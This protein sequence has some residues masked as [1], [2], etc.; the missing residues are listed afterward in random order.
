MSKSIETFISNVLS[1]IN[2]A[3]FYYSQNRE[4]EFATDCSDL[5]LRSLKAAGFDI[6]G[7]TYTGNMK[8]LLGASCD[9]DVLPFNMAN[10]KR[11]D[12]FLKHLSGSN[13]HTVLYL[14]GMRIAEASGKKYGLREAQYHPNG[15]QW[16][17]RPRENGESKCN[18]KTIKQGSKCIEV[19]L[20]QLFLNKYEGNRLSIDCDFGPKTAEAV[21]NF[22]GKHNLETDKIVGG[23]TWA[24]I[25][26]IMVTNS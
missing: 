20:L 6:N 11:G 17:I 3:R 25:Y 1:I 19:G 9:F 24:K 5:I 23:N 4:N 22:Q 13:G 7:A 14:G 10:S 18:M 12:I 16:I 15:Y 26:S 21:W 2:D 8:N